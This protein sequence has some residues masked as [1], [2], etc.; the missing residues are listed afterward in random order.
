[1]SA[2]TVGIERIDHRQTNTADQQYRERGEEQQTDD[3]NA[4]HDLPTVRRR[5]EQP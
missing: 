4:E 5:I 1:M 3:C 2:S